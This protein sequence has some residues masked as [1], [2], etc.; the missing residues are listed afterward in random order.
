MRVGQEPLERSKTGRA[1]CAY[2]LITDIM[3]N[4]VSGKTSAFLRVY[5]IGREDGAEHAVP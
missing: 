5:V 4:Y 1:W 2:L 3:L